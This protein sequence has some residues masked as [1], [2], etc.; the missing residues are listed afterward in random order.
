[1]TAI[2]VQLAEWQTVSPVTWESHGE[3]QPW[4]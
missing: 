1:M 2:A 4:I 3:C